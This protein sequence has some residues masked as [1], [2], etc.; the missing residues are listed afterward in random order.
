[1]SC[2]LLALAVH[3]DRQPGVGPAGRVG[4]DK[5]P[6]VVGGEGTEA[7][8]RAGDRLKRPRRWFAVRF[9]FDEVLPGPTGYSSFTSSQLAEPPVGFCE[10]AMVPSL[11]P[12]ATQ[13]DSLGHEIPESP[14]CTG[15]FSEFRIGANWRIVHVE[16][17]AGPAAARIANRTRAQAAATRAKTEIRAFL[18]GDGEGAG[19]IKRFWR[20]RARSQPD[21]S[22]ATRRLII[23]SPQ[24]ERRASNTG[25]C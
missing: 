15:S 1:M 3:V 18:C 22:S 25:G 14:I 12:T 17:V 23:E 7:L 13:S 9:S 2:A 16:A 20:K 10:T 8:R 19:V 6:A 4:G 11:P 5:D 21:W 24:C